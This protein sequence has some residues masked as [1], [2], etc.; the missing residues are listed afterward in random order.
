MLMNSFVVTGKI[1][2]FGTVNRGVVRSG[3]IT[4]V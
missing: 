2:N 1:I 3:L 4:M